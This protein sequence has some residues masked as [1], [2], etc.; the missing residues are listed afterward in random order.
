MFENTPHP[1]YVCER[2]GW[3]RYH[4]LSYCM[5]CP[6]KLVRKSIPHKYNLKTDIESREFLKTQGVIYNGEGDQFSKEDL[7]L[8]RIARFEEYLNSA[9]KESEIVKQNGNAEELKKLNN[10]IKFWEKE[11]N[12]LKLSLQKEP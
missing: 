10:I 1:M 5:Q 2:C 9:I 4:P 8:V 3:A 6:G 7:I 11:I 12:D